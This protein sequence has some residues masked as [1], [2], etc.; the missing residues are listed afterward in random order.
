MAVVEDCRVS[1]ADV[2]VFLAMP[3]HRDIPARTVVSLL[4]TLD[5]MR[6]KNI[7]FEIQIQN[8]GSIVTHARTKAVHSFLK[9]DKTRLFW[10]D[11]DIQWNPADFLRLL[12]LSV[13]LECIGALYPAKHDPIEFLINFDDYELETNDFGCFDL[14]GFGMGFLCLQRHVV[15]KVSAA[16]PKLR[17]PD[18]D[19]PIPHLFRLDENNG[20]ARGEDNAFFA[21][22]RALGYKTWVDP[23][24]K[25]GHIGQKI[26]AGDFM[27]MLTREQS[28]GEVAESVDGMRPQPREEAGL[29]GAA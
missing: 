8:G 12:A 28:G 25:L 21:D 11:S 29:R 23:S 1:L 2:S 22:V 10:V 15:E 19:E 24:V 9:T 16:A 18:I 4:G 13:K 6:D 5:L 20:Y 27:E 7:P 3:A 26:Y 14:K 17:F